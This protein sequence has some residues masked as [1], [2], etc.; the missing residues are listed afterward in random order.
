[1]RPEFYWSGL[2]TILD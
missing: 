1:L 2:S